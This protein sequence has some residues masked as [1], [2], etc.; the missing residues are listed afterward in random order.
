MGVLHGKG[1][2]FREKLYNIGKVYDF[3][4]IFAPKTLTDRAE[5]ATIPQKS[6]RKLIKSG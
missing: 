6:I 4:G 2:E 3:T 1:A 5:P